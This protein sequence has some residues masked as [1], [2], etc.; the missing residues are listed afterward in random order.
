[1]L[2]SKRRKI[3]KTKTEKTGNRTN[4]NSKNPIFTTQTTKGFASHETVKR[5]FK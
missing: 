4:Y 1:M 2:S 5:E 3:S